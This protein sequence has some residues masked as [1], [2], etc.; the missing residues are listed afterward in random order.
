MVMAPRR[1]RKPDSLTAAAG[2]PGMWRRNWTQRPLSMPFRLPPPYTLFKYALYALLVVDCGWF[3]R[4]DFDS[5]R[6]L[7]VSPID[8]PLL[9]AT[10]AQTIDT[11][12]WLSLLLLFELETGV[13]A[14]AT[15][16]GRR[17]T[18]LHASRA[19]CY[20]FVIYACTGYVR[21]LALFFGSVPWPGADNLCAIAGHDYAF[22]ISLDNYDAITARNCATLGPSAGLLQ[23]EGTRLLG[24]AGSIANARWLALTDVLNAVAWLLVAA[25]LELEVWV[26]VFFRRRNWLHSLHLGIKLI[27]YAT[28]AA[29]AL[30]WWS[31]GTFLDFWD[32]SLWIVAFAFIEMNVFRW[33]AV[34]RSRQGPYTLA[35]MDHGEAE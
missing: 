5:A 33:G 12:A 9:G 24:T 27:L 31:A 25:V 30:Y 6:H 11:W 8:W 29:A 20:G 22:V 4:E 1:Q 14:A 34:A 28:L 32:A 16:I 15:I 18:L 17:R 13:W 35:H 23:I 10:L 3:M 2:S 7:M 26:N 19:V 21:K